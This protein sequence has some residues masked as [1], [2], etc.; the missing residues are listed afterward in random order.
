MFLKGVYERVKKYSP[1][2]IGVLLA[3]I[4]AQGYLLY[5]GKGTTQ[6]SSFVPE[7]KDRYSS[8]NLMDK[9]KKRFKKDSDSTG[10]MFGNFFDDEFFSRGSDPFKEM[11]ELRRNIFKDFNNYEG[12]LFNKS[13]DDWYGRRFGKDDIEMFTEET[14]DEVVMRFKIPGLKKNTFNIDINENRIHVAYDA[15]IIN[16]KED[17]KGMRYY[18]SSQQQHISKTFPT[19]ANVDATRAEIDTKDEEVIVRLPKVE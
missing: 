4:I 2:L 11:E 14:D 3:V 9:L 8:S 1:V 17:D 10:D 16:E 15:K 19:P 5:K 12:N 7:S 13:W 18:Q 6:K